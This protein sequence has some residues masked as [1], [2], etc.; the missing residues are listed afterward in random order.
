MDS[1]TERRVQNAFWREYCSSYEVLCP[2]FTPTD[3]WECDIFG[4]TKA[5]LAH[6][7]EIKLS[8]ADFKADA[9]KDGFWL[10][11]E[12]R[13]RGPDTPD[14]IETLNKHELLAARS[15]RGPSRFYFVLPEELCDQVE[16][17]DWAGLR[18]ISR[19][20]PRVYVGHLRD[21]PLLHREKV[22]EDMLSQMRRNFY[23]RYW[24]ERNRTVEAR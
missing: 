10:G 1:L 15:P 17:P 4:V 11:N 2:N 8:V 3:W 9:A 6:E 13:S 18:G 21:A 23:F 5:G 24:R 20:G 14:S 12:L 7:F 22:S 19:S 16:L